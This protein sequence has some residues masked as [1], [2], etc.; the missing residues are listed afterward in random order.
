LVLLA[1]KAQQKE[2]PMQ[3]TLLGAVNLILRELGETPVTSVDETYPTLAQILPALEDARRTILAEGW[4]FNSFDDFTA[5][6]LPTGE[7]I[8]S[9]DTLAFYPEDVE[10]FTWAG[11]YVRVT[12]TGS[13]VVGAPVRGRIVLDMPFDELPESIRYLVVYRCAYEVYVADFGE[14]STAR[15][16]AAKMASAYEAARAVHIR[17]RK[18]TLRKRTPANQWRQARYN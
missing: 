12:S 8:L 10:K 3:L 14:D 1:E 13:K 11:R 16:I 6:P 7:V 4:W 2:T 5:S 15:V 9:E 18:L 17:Q